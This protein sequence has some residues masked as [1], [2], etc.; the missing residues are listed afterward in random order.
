MAARSA[1]A[2]GVGLLRV[3]SAAEN[4]VILQERV[5][6]AIFVDADDRE[7]VTAAASTVDALAV[8]PGIGADGKGAARLG[9]ALEGAGGLPVV[10]DADALTLVGAGEAPSLEE[11]GAAGPVLLTP[12]P[13]EMA[14]I[15]PDD[16][17]RI[18]ELPV[19]VARETA[20]RT[21]CTVL[22]KGLPSVV[23]PPDGPVVVD[24]VGTSDLATGGMGD[25]LTG[26]CGSYLAQGVE[27]PV[28][29]GA[30]ALHH[31]GRAAVRAGMGVGLTPEDVIAH[32]PAALSE[33]GPGT[34][35][36]ELPFVVFDRDPPR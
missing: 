18:L 29:A 31:S 21:G 36:L 4:R 1:L 12:H 10:V 7:A 32:L 19:E 17:E 6:E 33:R 27:A 5:P 28:R 35:D 13:G 3:A 11:L 9:A 14:R 24:A 22:L 16:R 8:G 34:T 26:V 30:L 20:R 25:V 2:S 15:V 23:A